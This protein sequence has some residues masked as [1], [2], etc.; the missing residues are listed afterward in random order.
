MNDLPPFI[1]FPRTPHLFPAAGTERCK[2]DKLLTPEA[3]E[4][5]LDG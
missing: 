4:A 3:R 2:D 5:F 1:K